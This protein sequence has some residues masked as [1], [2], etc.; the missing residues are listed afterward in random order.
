MM[1][2]EIKASKSGVQV[3]SHSKTS[4]VQHKMSSVPGKRKV[5]RP[6]LNAPRTI[7]IKKEPASQEIPTKKPRRRPR[8]KRS[9][10]PSVCSVCNEKF[11]RPVDLLRHRVVH[12]EKALL[13]CNWCGVTFPFRSQLMNHIRTH[14]GERPFS[15]DLCGKTFQS[16]SNLRIHMWSHKPKETGCS[17][18][19]ADSPASL[20]DDTSRRR[21][22][23]PCAKCGKIK[24]V[25]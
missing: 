19:S 9:N 10:F 17:L 2:F 8:G 12:N 20:E 3:P 25:T 1:Q 22:T 24:S 5:G 14:T 6:R 18:C 13:P 4:E 11:S 16:N 21:S 23:R 7:A 15:C